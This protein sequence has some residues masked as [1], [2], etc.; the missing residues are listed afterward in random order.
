[1]VKKKKIILI[2]CPN[3]GAEVLPDIFYC[4][5]CKVILTDYRKGR[6]KIKN[7]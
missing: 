6:I 1:M 5:K 2:H 4:K 3:C 7:D